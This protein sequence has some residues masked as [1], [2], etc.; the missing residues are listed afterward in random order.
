MNCSKTIQIVI[1][2]CFRLQQ[3]VE[4]KQKLSPLFIG[5]SE[6]SSIVTFTDLDDN[7]SINGGEGK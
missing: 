5:P 6:T 3:R 2:N 1:F 7:F 4:L